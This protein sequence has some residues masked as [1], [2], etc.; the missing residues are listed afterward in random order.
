MTNH[1]LKTEEP[2]FTA[3]REHRKNFELRIDDRGYRIGDT[4]CLM[5]FIDGKVTGEFEEREITYIL[6]GFAGLT[7]GWCIL[8]LKDVTIIGGIV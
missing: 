1:T 6:R 8:S 4:V 7:F 5:Q 2:Y 3:V